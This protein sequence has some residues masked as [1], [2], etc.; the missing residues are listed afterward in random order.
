M[1]AA[2]PWRDIHA[3]ALGNPFH[4]RTDLLYHARYVRAEDM[5]KRHRIG[6]T[7]LPDPDVEMVQGA[8][9]DPHQH[10]IDADRRHRHLLILQLPRPAMFVEHH[11]IHA[12]SK[13]RRLTVQRSTFNA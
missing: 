5:R 8:G 12:S 4:M 6:G 13:S 9:F 10:F 11:C 1:P 3:F 7:A 2:D